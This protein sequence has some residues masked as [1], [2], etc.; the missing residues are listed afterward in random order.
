MAESDISKV[1]ICVDD[2]PIIL[3]AMKQEL[4]LHLKQQA[5]VE[6]W[7]RA[8]DALNRI[9][10]YRGR[11]VRVIL[12]ISDWLMPGMS[13]DEFL[14][15]LHERYPD[16]PVVLITGQAE[17]SDIE[18]LR[19]RTGLKHVLRKPWRAQELRG[20]VDAAFQA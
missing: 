16:I 10:E 8:E 19:T 11:D 6:T 9:A 15:A 17:E 20:I 14:S 4:R 18:S 5:A 2:E 12:V 3:M 1:L 13:G 7:G